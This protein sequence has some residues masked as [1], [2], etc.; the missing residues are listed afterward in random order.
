LEVAPFLALDRRDQLSAAADTTW[1]HL[2]NLDAV[3]LATE[4][5]M[6]FVKDPAK[7][8]L[9][10]G[11]FGPRSDEY[12]GELNSIRYFHYLDVLWKHI[13]FDYYLTDKTDGGIVSRSSFVRE[14]N[15][16]ILRSLDISYE[17]INE[18]Q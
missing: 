14:V 9:Y 6:A 5:A 4:D 3:I 17:I 1:Y 12:I 10:P 18:V 16:V 7:T 13:K 11:P 8:A 15:I 2:E